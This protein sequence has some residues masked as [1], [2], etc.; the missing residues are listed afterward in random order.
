MRTMMIAGKI[1]RNNS[2]GFKG[3]ARVTV[4]KIK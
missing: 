4:G 3:C 1:P 2:L